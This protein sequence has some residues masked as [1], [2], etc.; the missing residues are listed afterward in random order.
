[1]L[2]TF[3]FSVVNLYRILVYGKLLGDFTFKCRNQDLCES[4]YKSQKGEIYSD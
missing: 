3:W 1:M 2:K 4:G